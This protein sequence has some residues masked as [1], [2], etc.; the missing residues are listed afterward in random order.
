MIGSPQRRRGAEIEDTLFSPRFL[1]AAIDGEG[2]ACAIEVNVGAAEME[3]LPK[4]DD[5][6]AFVI[7]AIMARIRER[8]DC[9]CE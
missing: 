5:A 3:V 2:I 9:L 1:L 4:Y 7:E 6:K 8:G